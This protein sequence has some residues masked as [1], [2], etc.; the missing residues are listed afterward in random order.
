MKNEY[1]N[2][3][4]HLPPLS[5]TGW[6]VSIVHDHLPLP[7]AACIN[8]R[9]IKVSNLSKKSLLYPSIFDY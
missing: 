6:S 4:E 9:E 7:Y 2:L 8:C 5:P 1:I 3:T